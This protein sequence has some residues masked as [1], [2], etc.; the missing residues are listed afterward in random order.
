MNEIIN[1]R[2]TKALVKTILEEDQRARNSD[3]YLVRQNIAYLKELK[4]RRVCDDLK[5]GAE[6]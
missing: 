1:L 5:E 3:S 6:E 2:T 4:H